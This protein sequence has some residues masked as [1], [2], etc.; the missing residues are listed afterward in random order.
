MGIIT[1]FIAR[2]GKARSARK[3][4]HQAT[5]STATTLTNA[6]LPS[7]QT[8]AH[9][10]LAEICRPVCANSGPFI[11]LPG[12]VRNLIYKY[13]FNQSLSADQLPDTHLLPACSSLALTCRQIYHEVHDM[14][15]S[16]ILVYGLHT[17]RIRFFQQLPHER[18]SLMKAVILPESWMG[19]SWI[20]YHDWRKGIYEC[21][22]KRLCASD[23][24]PTT[25]IFCTDSKGSQVSRD[26]SGISS[27]AREARFANALKDLRFAL[28]IM[29]TIRTVYLVDVG[30]HEGRR[31]YADMFDKFFPSDADKV[32]RIA[33][34]FNS[35]HYHSTLD[36]S[37]KWTVKRERVPIRPDDERC[38]R[39]VSGVHDDLVFE[40]IE[41]ADNTDNTPDFRLIKPHLEL[42]TCEIVVH[43]FTSWPDFCNAYDGPY[44][45]P[46][47][48]QNRLS[49]IPVTRYNMRQASWH[50][51]Q[52]V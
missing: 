5:Y 22:T 11:N 8:A 13:A 15:D 37:E 52:D 18:L 34:G 30:F 23:F 9:L 39:L 17:M 28:S 46:K 41:E 1:R 10:D 6:Q 27:A 50:L 19:D 43:V 24:R 26:V 32:S 33:R 51:G 35:L 44:R 42:P 2:L 25:L 31:H 7:D 36:G 14:I 29:H 40:Q 3:P 21:V 12:E 48:C 49:K 38:S 4:K 47:R 45:S 20:R 16:N